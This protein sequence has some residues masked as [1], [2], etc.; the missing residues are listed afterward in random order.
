MARALRPAMSVKEWCHFKAEE[1][2]A[3]AEEL[4]DLDCKTKILRNAAT[5]DMLSKRPP[6]LTP[7][8]QFVVATKRLYDSCAMGKEKELSPSYDDFGLWHLDD[9]M[10]PVIRSKRATALTARISADFRPL[11]TGA[12]AAAC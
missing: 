1:S 7:R 8:R 12:S 5:W 2:R 3:I 9:L 10:I 4:F 11:S 6:Y